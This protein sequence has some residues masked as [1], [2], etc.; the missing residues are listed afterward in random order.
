MFSRLEQ[1]I[2]LKFMSF[3]ISKENTSG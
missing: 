1:K 2:L 3:I